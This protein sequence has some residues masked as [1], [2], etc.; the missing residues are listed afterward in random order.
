M[1]F[2]LRISQFV[3]LMGCESIKATY[4]ILDAENVLSHSS[5]A[6]NT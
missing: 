5:Q 6:A 4:N 1:D 3:G 2:K